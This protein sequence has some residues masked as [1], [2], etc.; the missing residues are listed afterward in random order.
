MDVVKPLL[1]RH[2]KGEDVDLVDCEED[3]DD[4]KASH[5]HVF[6]K[7]AVTSRKVTQTLG[8]GLVA[9]VSLIVAKIAEC[10]IDGSTSSFDSVP[11]QSSIK[12]LVQ[13][14]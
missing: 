7:V 3:G 4:A 5:G 13:S 1:P 12:F 8:I 2:E 10:L 9:H 11:P 14:C 6:K